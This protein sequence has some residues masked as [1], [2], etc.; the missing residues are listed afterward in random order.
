M[1]G[2]ETSEVRIHNM[3]VH[4]KEVLKINEKE[5]RTFEYWVMELLDMVGRNLYNF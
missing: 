3:L 1:V 5:M 2:F 4:T